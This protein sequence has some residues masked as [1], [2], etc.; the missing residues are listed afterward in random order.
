MSNKQ[1]FEISAT[2]VL[3]FIVLSIMFYSLYMYTGFK[4]IIWIGAVISFAFGLVCS[5]AVYTLKEYEN[6]KK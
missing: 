4:E 3:V 1:W 2:G 5:I 6:K